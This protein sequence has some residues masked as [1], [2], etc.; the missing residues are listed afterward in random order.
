MVG[1]GGNMKTFVFDEIKCPCGK[2]A[3]LK[4]EDEGGLQTFW[5][6]YCGRLGEYIQDTEDLIIE[7]VDWSVRCQNARH[8]Y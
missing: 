5:S 1:N 6:P 3:E 4:S 8:N 2:D 7:D